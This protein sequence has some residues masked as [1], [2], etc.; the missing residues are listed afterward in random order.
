MGVVDVRI[1]PTSQTQPGPCRAIA[2]CVAQVCRLTAVSAASAQPHLQNLSAGTPVGSSGCHRRRRRRLLSHRRVRPPRCSPSAR[3]LPVWNA[4]SAASSHVCHCAQQRQRRRRPAA[5]R[6]A[7]AP[8]PRS[9]RAAPRRTRGL[10]VSASLAWPSCG[11]G[12]RLPWRLG[13]TLRG[14]L[15]PCSARTRWASRRWPLAV[16]R[17]T[18]R[19]SISRRLTDRV[20]CTAHRRQE[21]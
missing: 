18:P 13:A 8:P 20:A 12:P 6:P 1:L 19:D 15:L 14:S 5:R 21:R 9:A 2:Q 10:C 17:L 4:A 16:G 3:Q 7:A 11:A